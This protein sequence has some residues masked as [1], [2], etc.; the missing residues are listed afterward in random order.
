VHP[1]A[2]YA[3][4]HGWVQL[5]G[6]SPLATRYTTVLCGIGAIATIGAAGR[7]LGGPTAGQVAGLIVAMT[8]GVALL[9]TTVRDFTPGL[10][11]AGLAVEAWLRLW[12]RSGD[13]PH[14]NPLPEG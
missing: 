11:L 1:P 4:L 7:R 14:P 8:P 13:G 9:A 10:L 2:Y 12:C 6:L 5:A 3:L